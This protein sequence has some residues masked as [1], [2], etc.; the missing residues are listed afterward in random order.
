MEKTWLFFGDQ[1]FVT[2]FLYQR[3]WQNW[4]K[5]GVLT[6]M[7]VAFS[8]D[9]EEKVYVQHKMLKQAKELYAWLEKGAMFTYVEIKTW[10]KMFKKH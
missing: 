4:L 8:R 3:E 9:Q 1:H 10:Q 2:D 7:D 6:K 5:S